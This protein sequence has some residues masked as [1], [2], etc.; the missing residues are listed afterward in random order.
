MALLEHV[1]TRLRVL[2]HHLVEGNTKKAQRLA[3]AA[4]HDA[5]VDRGIIA[6][7]LIET[8]AQEQ[9]LKNGGLNLPSVFPGIGTLISFLLA[10]AENLL[11]LDQ[12]VSVILALRS[13]HGCDD[14]EG[15]GEDFVIQVMGEAYKLTD[16]LEP[17]DLQE[18]T[19]RYMTQELPQ[20]YMNVG[21]NKLLSR[22]FPY[23]RQLR[24]VPIIG[25][26]ISAYD[27]YKTVVTVG[28]VTLKYLQ[29][30]QF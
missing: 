16:P 9:A 8:L 12:S 3:E 28:R 27:G 7:N 10:G 30:Q 14:G 17:A 2:I 18:I 13:L 20:R 6:Q 21:M 23:R 25:V 22:L 4:V 29:K 24:L 15:R 26:F 1:G 19:R 11:I 5:S